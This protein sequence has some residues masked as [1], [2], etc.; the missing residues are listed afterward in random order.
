MKRF[1]KWTLILGLIFCLTG[2]GT[3]TAGAMMGG[4]LP[5]RNYPLWTTIIRAPGHPHGTAII[6]ESPAAAGLEDAFC[7]ENV[8]DLKME[9]LGNCIELQM[10]EQL[11]DGQVRISRDGGSKAMYEICQEGGELSLEIP[12]AWPAGNEPESLVIWVP[13]G[14]VFDEV[15]IESVGGRFSADQIN[16]CELSLECGGGEIEIG[17]GSVQKLDVEC[18]AGRIFCQAVCTGDTEVECASGDVT[19]T[20]AGPASECMYDVA[21]A[22]GHVSIDGQSHR[23]F[24]RAHQAH[25]G[26]SHGRHHGGAKVD[27][28]CAAGSVAVNFQ[29]PEV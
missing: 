5:V 12:D 25:H 15:E 6:P 13:Q 28:D 27:L 10:S 17:G 22:M 3:V 7:Y 16:A 11:S 23:D 1:L 18:G 24:M 8:R 2:I 19:V 29:K 4:R 20:L 9:L 21:C 14:F 26:E